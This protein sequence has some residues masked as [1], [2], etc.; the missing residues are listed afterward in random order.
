MIYLCLAYMSED[1]IEQIYVKE[2]FDTNWVVSMGPNVNAFE[3]ELAKMANTK[4]DGSEPL[5]VT[6]EYVH[7]VF[8]CN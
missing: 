4:T 6:Y 3:Q 1:G 7:D 8:G 2:T 5:S